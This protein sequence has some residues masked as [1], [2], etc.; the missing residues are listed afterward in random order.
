MDEDNGTCDTIFTLSNEEME[1]EFCFQIISGDVA[2]NDTIELR[3]HNDGVDTVTY[4]NTPSITV[5]E[6]GG[7]DVNLAVPLTNI[8]ETDL[9]PSV[10]IDVGLAVPITNVG[11]TDLAPAVVIDW[12][13]AVPLTNIGETQF[14]PAVFVDVN[15]SPS[16]QNV[17]ITEYA[18]TVDAGGS[19]NPFSWFFSSIG[20][21]IKWRRSS[22]NP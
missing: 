9:A 10:V 6:G 14:S 7:S 15:L 3:Q 8:G 11:E 19:S 4:T 5:N 17:G 1:H 22:N 2:D 21:G 12:S 20:T 18:P 16:L 13:A